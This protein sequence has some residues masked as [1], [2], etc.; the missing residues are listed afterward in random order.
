M[1]HVKD[2]TKRKTN[3][4][5]VETISTARKHKN[6]FPIAHIISGS[7]KD[8]SAINLSDLDSKTKAGDTIIITGKLLGSGNLTKKIRICALSAS[9]DALDK[10][11]HS[12][13]EFVTILEEIKKN[14]KAEG[15]KLIR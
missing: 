1:T 3:P 10:L 13:S 2:K 9:K 11:K 6:W 8:Y 4:I 7:N 12:K 15:V 14:P 5:L